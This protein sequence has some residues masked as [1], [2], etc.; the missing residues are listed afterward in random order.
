[1]TKPS[2][3]WVFAGS[4][5]ETLD[6]AT[7]LE[8]S[9]GLCD[10]GWNVTLVASDVPSREVD[11][12]VKVVRLPKPNVYPAGYFVFHL[13]LMLRFISGRLPADVVLLHEDSAPF[14]LPFSLPRRVLRRTVP[15]LVLDSR[16]VPM[17]MA[18]RRDRMRAAQFRIGHALGN[19]LADA[20]TAITDRL[21][22]AAGI[23]RDRLV[24][25]WPSGV[26]IERFRAAS[27]VRAWPRS[28]D[29]LRLIYAGT[30]YA[31]RNLLG[32]C[33]AVQA[34]RS[35]GLPVTLELLGDGPQ[36]S[37]LAR[38]ARDTSQDGI[39]VKPAVPHADVPAA[40]AEAHLGVLPFPN[41]VEF[42]VSSPVKLFEYLAAGM[43]VVA[44]RVVCH[45]DVLKNVDCVFWA[46][47]ESATGIA[48]AI[49]AAWARRSELA[50]MAGRAAA[51][52][53]DWS[54]EASASRLDVALRHALKRSCCRAH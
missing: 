28:G 45:T 54:W 13:S 49:R 43:P 22:E 29:P 34:V 14:L 25:V 39:S 53:Q 5:S 11:R 35:E 6:R 26:N 44:T 42:R 27:G 47:D 40:L 33:E 3:V 30:L 7:W 37:E 36:A 31:E 17:S 52:A 46:E 19:R 16:T 20:Q 1:M 2:L 24:G 50:L 51:V 18:T 9:A 32:L 10:L 15:S 48:S 21:V 23:D 8:T 4:L 38:Y 12:R 41:T